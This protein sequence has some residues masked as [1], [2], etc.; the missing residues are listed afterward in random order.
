MNEDQ[1]LN[2]RYV[3]YLA[4]SQWIA[5]PIAVI[6]LTGFALTAINTPDAAVAVGIIVA[7]A[8]AFLVV[9]LA[10]AYGVAYLSYRAYRYSIN[11][12]GFH[13]KFGVLNRKSTT[14]PFDRIQNIDINEP[15]IMRIFGLC[16]LH[17]QTA[18]GSSFSNGTEGRL[19]GITQQEALRLKDELLARAKSH[20]GL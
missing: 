12:Q 11:A 2:K 17:V 6:F 19:P 14:I 10:A 15:L 18:G 9:A 1:K 20:R 3:H 13:K 16:E 5:A 4:I 8:A 7:L